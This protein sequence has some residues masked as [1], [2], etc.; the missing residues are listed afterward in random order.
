MTALLGIS[1]AIDWF[2]TWLG[3]VMFWLTLLMVLVGA[4]N[5]IT[6]YLGRS[7]GMQL[8]SNVYLELQTYMYDM[9]FMLGAAYVLKV[10]GHVRV[11]LIY[12]RFSERV[13]AWIDIFA[14]VFLL[15]PFCALGIAFSQSY[16]ARSWAQLEMSPNANGL[17][18]YPIKTLIIVTFVL[19]I[20]QGISEIIKK[21]AFLSGR[22][23]PEPTARAHQE[24]L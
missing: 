15:F 10:D 19:L 9:V 24:S 11:D 6:R 3:R 20:L 7:L 1:K 13:R 14:T 22:L 17:P 23:R 16:V 2:T 5:V 8:S 21:A 12:S 4:Y 18:R